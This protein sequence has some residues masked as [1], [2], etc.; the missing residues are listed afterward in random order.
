MDNKVSRRFIR[1]QKRIV[2]NY[3]PLLQ[4]V[5]TVKCNDEDGEIT[6]WLFKLL[7]VCMILTFLLSLI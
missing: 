6:H 7:A 4:I 1:L 5:E 2:G 3:N